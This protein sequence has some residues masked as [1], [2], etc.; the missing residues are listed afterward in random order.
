LAETAWL[1]IAMIA[2]IASDAMAPL[3]AH[4]LIC[5][6]SYCRNR[7]AASPPRRPA[8]S[9]GHR[10]SELRPRGQTVSGSDSLGAQL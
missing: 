2:M 3:P 10:L 9:G 7:L 8:D 5:T 6:A 4:N 1:K